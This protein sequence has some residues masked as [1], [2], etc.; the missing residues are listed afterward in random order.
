M[1]SMSTTSAADRTGVAS[2]SPAACQPAAGPPAGAGAGP[3]PTGPA[4][5]RPARP[6]PPGRGQDTGRGGTRAGLETALRFATLWLEVEAGLRPSSLL[7]DLA[8]PRALPG[9]GTRQ[10]A[11]AGIVRRVRAVDGGA[12]HLDVVALVD[13]GGRFGALTLRLRSDGG[14]QW[15]VIEAGCP[16]DQ[17]R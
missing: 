6:R 1:S 3:A 2:R 15:T 13:R 5:R 10:R 4:G 8:L 7:R 12:Q 11:R 16:E 14:G 17:R 9:R